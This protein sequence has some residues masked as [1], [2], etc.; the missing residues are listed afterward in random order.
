MKKIT[1]II[2][3]YNTAQILKECLDNLSS[4]Y[5]NMEVIVV[6][7]ASTD[8]SAEIVKSNYPNVLLI[9]SQ[10]KGIS[11]AT[12]LALK[13]ATGDFILHL[14]TDAFPK[15]DDLIKMLSYME[16]NQDVGIVTPRLVTR[17]GR[18]DMDAHRAFPT[19]LVAFCHFTHLDRVLPKSPYLKTYFLEHENLETRH[20]IDLC[21]S[22]FMLVRAEVYRDVPTWDEDY[23]VFGEDVDF[24]YR[25]K[26]A[27]WRIMYLGD[28]TVLHYKGVSVGRPESRDIKTVSNSS[29]ETRLKMRRATT[30]AMRLFYDK[31]YSKR[32]SK[33]VTFP[34]YLA[35][36]FLELFRIIKTRLGK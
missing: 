3:S 32:Y 26:S 13:Q 27:K 22:H 31:H 7:N 10:N 30:Q 11:Y 25:V 15:K 5:E 20:E 8:G 24:C 6:D 21:I 29:I 4:N 28:I 14:G 16:D 36:N 33:L 9:Q 1:C 18:P 23:F 19:P 12:N 34:I 17:D 35:I 2:V